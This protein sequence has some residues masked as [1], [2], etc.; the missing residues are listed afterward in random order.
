MRVASAIDFGPMASERFVAVA[1]FVAAAA[2]WAMK[3]ERRET[4]EAACVN[5]HSRPQTSTS[6][7]RVFDRRENSYK[8]N[9]RFSSDALMTLK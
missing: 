4:S 1:A 7:R 5:E 6:E 9:A 3:G 8:I 2:V